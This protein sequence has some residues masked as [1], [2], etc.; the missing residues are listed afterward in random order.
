MIS[1]TLDTY[2]RSCLDFDRLQTVNTIDG[3]I[4]EI[5]SFADCTELDVKNYPDTIQYLSKF[6]FTVR[7]GEDT[8]EALY[9]YEYD[10]RAKRVDII[11]A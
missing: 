5:L 8:G 1:V 11:R 9:Y 3:Y 6:G 10:D 7:S 4:K 2:A